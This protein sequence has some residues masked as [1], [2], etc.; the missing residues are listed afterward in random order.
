MW[1]GSMLNVL[2]APVHLRQ[3]VSDNTL[4]IDNANHWA[5]LLLEEALAI[6]QDAPL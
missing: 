3:I 1:H 4:I 6:K 5:P 2:N